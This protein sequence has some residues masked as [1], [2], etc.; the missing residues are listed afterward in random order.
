[1]RIFLAAPFTGQVQATASGT[2]LA[3]DYRSFLESV[4]A[5]LRG[6]GHAVVSSHEREDWGER[7]FEPQEAIGL[8]FKEVQACDLLLAL[9]GDPI[10]PGVQMEL[11]Y[12]LALQRPI[13]AY[14]TQARNELPHLLQGIDVFPNA[15]LSRYESSADLLGQLKRALS[16]RANLGR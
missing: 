12:A 7:I 1:L 15:T 13:S 4:L 11:G 3:A 2:A 16:E 10:S 14:H 9:V 8:D 6:Q 5:L